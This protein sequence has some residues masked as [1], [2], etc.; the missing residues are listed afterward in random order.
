V[1]LINWLLKPKYMLMHIFEFVSLYENTIW[2]FFIIERLDR[3]HEKK[4]FFFIQYFAMLWW[5]PGILIPNL[6]LYGIKIQI[7][8][9]KIDK[10]KIHGKITNF[11]KGFF[12]YFYCAG[13][14]PMHFDLGHTWSSLVN[15]GKT[16]SLCFWISSTNF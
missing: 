2:I 10:K 7:I 1:T 14:S 9:S 13:P 4:I 5:K 6:Y 12:E 8:L 3:M 15:C 11:S 16:Q